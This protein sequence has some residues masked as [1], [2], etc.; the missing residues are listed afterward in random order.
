[1]LKKSKSIITIALIFLLCF[2]SIS[3]A[4]ATNL[5]GKG[6]LHAEDEDTPLEVAISK[7]LRLPTGTTIPTATFTFV[8]TPISVNTDTAKSGPALQNLSIS[9]PGTTEF[10]SDTTAS[11]IRSLVLETDNIFED[12]SFPHAGIYV[13]DI[14]EQ[15]NTNTSI[16]NDSNR[17]LNYSP[18]KYR[19]TVY[20]A[21]HPTE[22]ERYVAAV[23]AQVIL[24]NAGVDGAEAKVDPTP[25]GYGQ[26]YS[27]SQM[28]FENNYLITNAQPNPEPAVRSTLFV[29]KVVDGFLASREQYFSFTINLTVPSLGQVVPEFLR[30]YVVENGAVVSNITANA[31]GVTVGADATVNAYPYIQITTGAPTTI[32][33]RDGQR[34]VL[35]DTP[36]GT[37]YTVTEAAA[38]NYTPNVLVTTNN[39]TPINI[40]GSLNQSLSTGSQLVGEALNGNSAAF[41][42]TRDEVVPTGLNLNDLPF[43]LLIA[44]GIGALTVYIVVKTRKGK[45]E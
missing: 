37:S 17:W 38:T 28:V 19:L 40:E 41:T 18:A 30:G 25:G 3:T 4:F 11:N 32:L 16:D 8:A 43:V 6:A 21:S 26:D 34:L 31:N 44:L 35:V 39:G 27:Y 29:S 20:V 13:Y 45:A 33:L 14:T 36:V 15:H 1:M 22:D 23:T 24:N 2:A 7:R 9:F 12:V 5:D 10:A 42:N